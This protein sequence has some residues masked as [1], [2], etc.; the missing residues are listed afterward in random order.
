MTPRSI[1]V[2]TSA[3][4]G[5]GI[6]NDLIRGVI[7]FSQT[8]N[9]RI[10]CISSMVL[11]RVLRSGEPVDGLVGLLRD[12][13]VVDLVRRRGIPAVSTADVLP[14]LGLPLVCQDDY[15]IGRLAAEDFLRR[16][17][18]TFGVYKYGA[19]NFSA[20]R[21]AG[22]MDAIKRAGHRCRSRLTRRRALLGSLTL[23][24]SDAPLLAWVRSLHRPAAVFAINDSLGSHLLQECLFADVHVPGD[25]AVIGVDN[26]ETVCHLTTPPLS[27][28]QTSGESIGYKAAEVLDRMLAGLP[29]PAEP[30]R[31]PPLRI[32]TRQSS[33]VYAVQDDQ[34]AMALRQ[35]RKHAH[36]HIGVKGLL[37]TLGGIDRR[38]LERK[39]RALIGRGPG[40]ELLRVRIDHAR[41]LLGSTEIPVR[42]VARDC[43][44]AVARHFSLAFRRETGLRPT[45]FRRQTRARG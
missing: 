23:S 18:K 17:F 36:E 19:L 37:A 28:V 9:W 2:S 32:V 25:M 5:H 24:G 7:A 45:A 35:I 43:G 1:I 38:T 11:M 3:R 15:A 10:R 14:D 6:W 44:F 42:Q 41:E 21:A 12:P 22:F 31:I 33:D 8:R 40:A 20:R 13:A 26:E 4:V 29:A 27:S 34:L 39:F 30:I 16:G